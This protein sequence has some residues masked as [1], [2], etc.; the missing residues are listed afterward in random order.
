MVLIYGIKMTL[1]VSR[2]VYRHGAQIILQFD[3][4]RIAL[5]NGDEVKRVA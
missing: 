3:L 4:L 1:L 5:N 2:I